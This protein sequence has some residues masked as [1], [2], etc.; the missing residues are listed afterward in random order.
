MV[1]SLNYKDACE[2]V[3]THTISGETMEELLE[4]AKKGIECQ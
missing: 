3:C 4:N 1:R 2:P